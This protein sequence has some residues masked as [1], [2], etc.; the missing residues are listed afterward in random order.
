MA[1]RS[2]RRTQSKNE[3]LGMIVSCVG[4]YALLLGISPILANGAIGL[5]L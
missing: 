4:G 5:F 2:R 3:I 1:T